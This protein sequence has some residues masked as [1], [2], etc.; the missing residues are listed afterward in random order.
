[1]YLPRPATHP[2]SS[3][4]M[5]DGSLVYMLIASQKDAFSQVQLLAHVPP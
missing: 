1:M 2:L 4:N 5:S 3:Q